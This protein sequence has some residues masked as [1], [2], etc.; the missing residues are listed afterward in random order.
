MLGELAIEDSDVPTFRL[1]VL[2]EH[3]DQHVKARHVLCALD[4]PTFVLLWEAAVEHPQRRDL[5]AK[6]TSHQQE[7]LQSGKREVVCQQGE[8][9][10]RKVAMR[11]KEERVKYRFRDDVPHVGLTL[12][13]DDLRQFWVNDNLP[14]H[15]REEHARLLVCRC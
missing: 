7:K 11:K 6:V 13:G 1:H 10:C 14:P 2:V 9:I 4:M 12:A 5:L 8:R 3:P 15:K